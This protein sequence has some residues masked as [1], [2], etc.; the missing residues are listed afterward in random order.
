MKC[1]QKYQWVKLP[2]NTLPIGKGI[3]GSWMKLASRAAFR[4]GVAFYCGYENAVEPGM[5]AGG[6]VG[7]KS[8]LGVRSRAK[9]LET[10][11][12]LAQL[13]YLTYELDGNKEADLPDH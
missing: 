13:G 10:L 8:I 3:M 2:R 11:E 9:A 7:L 4:K 6:V 12:K 1:L 5:W